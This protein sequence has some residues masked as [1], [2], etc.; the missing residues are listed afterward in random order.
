[1]DEALATKTHGVEDHGGTPGS[2]S[3]KE[4]SLQASTLAYHLD[5]DLVSS[6]SRLASSCCDSHPLG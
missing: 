1:M 4:L 5:F 2:G 3:Y 6:A